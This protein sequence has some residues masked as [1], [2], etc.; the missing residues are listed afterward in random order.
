MTTAKELTENLIAKAKAMQTF[1]IMRQL[2]DA[3]IIFSA[4]IVPFDLKINKEG[5]M[6]ATVYALTL[7]EANDQVDTWLRHLE[8]GDR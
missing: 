2:D 8:E 6:V 4:G 3:D 7:E 1:R 5:R